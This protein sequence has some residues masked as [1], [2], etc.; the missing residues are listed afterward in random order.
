MSKVLLLLLIY[1]LISSCLTNTELT[2]QNIS[3][4]NIFTLN[5]NQEF[6]IKPQEDFQIK[7]HG[8][9]TT[10][11]SWSIKTLFEDNEYITLL[12]KDNS[13][14]YIPDETDKHIVGSGGN[15]YFTF[16]ANKP[17]K[18]AIIFKYQRSWEDKPI[19][20]L[21]AVIQIDSTITAISQASSSS[22]SMKIIYTLV[23]AL[24]LALNIE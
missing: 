17:G 18:T 15:F 23:I 21:K 19:Q 9:P 12:D 3:S 8:N 7:I 5:S 6:F 1:T 2:I 10:G 4:Q 20:E 16:R 11:Y 24:I 13:G 22:I 14:V